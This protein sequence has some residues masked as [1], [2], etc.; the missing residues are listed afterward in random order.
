MQT[1]NTVRVVSS[2]DADSGRRKPYG[3]APIELD[4]SDAI[5]LTLKIGK[6]GPLVSLTT[7]AILAG[8]TVTSSATTRKIS[9]LQ[10]YGL[11]EKQGSE[12]FALTDLGKSIVFPRS[13]Q[14][15]MEAKKEA[16]L[17]VSKYNLVYQ[18]N[19]GK[20][21]PADEFLKNIFEQ[22]GKIPRE[23]S[24]R[25]VEAF[26]SGARVAGLLHD[27]GAGRIQISDSPIMPSEPPILESTKSAVVA[28]ALERAP[29]RQASPEEQGS[30][31]VA[32][33]RKPSSGHF[34]CIELSDGQHAEFSVPDH[35]TA[36]D[37]N[38][39]KRALDGLKAI[40]ESMI[41]E[42]VSE[43]HNE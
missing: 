7:L 33:F 9:A 39:L 34:T 4:L 1:R 27:R 5:D 37:A 41:S 42:P 38:K 17:N 31:S 40:I 18:Q 25:W 2:G 22:D 13:G 10:S 32:N 43:T 3:T 35:L 26:K 12:Q 11:L 14:A 15:A 36:K 6:E 19:K 24:E 29:I 28:P 8:H 20:L 23:Y 30:R 16:F 21:L